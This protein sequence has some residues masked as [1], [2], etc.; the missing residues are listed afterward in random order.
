[1]SS[2]LDEI[3]SSVVRIRD[4]MCVKAEMKQL[5]KRCGRVRKGSVRTWVGVSWGG[6]GGDEEGTRL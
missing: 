2:F 4:V 3:L 5:V 1:M 6:R